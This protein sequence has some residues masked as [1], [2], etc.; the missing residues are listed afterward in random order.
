MRQAGEGE[1]GTRGLYDRCP[2]IKGFRPPSEIKLTNRGDESLVRPL[3]ASALLP[4]QRLYPSRRP[5]AR[6]FLPCPLVF[7]RGWSQA[8]RFQFEEKEARGWRGA[9]WIRPRIRDGGREDFR[10]YGTALV[11]RDSSSVDG[12]APGPCASTATTMPF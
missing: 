7:R 9:R 11:P 12:K 5:D 3:L 1:E 8:C 4:E 6:F 10:N 2:E